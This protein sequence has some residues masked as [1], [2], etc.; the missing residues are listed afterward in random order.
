MS[1][2]CSG[3]R[4]FSSHARRT[5]SRRRGRLRPRTVS[6]TTFAV[7]TCSRM[8]RTA[9]TRSSPAII[10]DDE[11]GWSARAL[12]AVEAVL[13]LPSTT[14]SGWSSMSVAIA[15]RAAVVDEQD[16]DGIFRSRH[17]SPRAE[18]WARGRRHARGD[19]RTAARRG[20]DRQG[21]PMSP[22]APMGGSSR[23]GRGV[24]PRSNRPSSSMTI[25]V[26]SCPRDGRPPTSPGSF[27]RSSAPPDDADHLDPAR[28]V[29]EARPRGPCERGGDAGLLR[30]LHEVGAEF[31]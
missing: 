1:Y 11:V 22:C 2:S 29:R 6:M 28:G 14:K 15:G 19:A 5:G 25:V 27:G 7:G 20:I 4:S 10:H 24:P 12:D 16:P 30:V 9:S 17:Q 26:A 23:R 3:R 31:R 21:T 18:C 8:S 13:G